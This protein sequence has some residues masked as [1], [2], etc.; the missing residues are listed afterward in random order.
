MWFAL[1]MWQLHTFFVWETGA[2]INF[3]LV[4]HYVVK[5]FKTVFAISFF[6]TLVCNI[7]RRKG[8]STCAQVLFHFQRNSFLWGYN[9]DLECRYSFWNISIT[10]YCYKLSFIVCGYSFTDQMFG[11]FRVGFEKCSEWISILFCLFILSRFK[12]FCMKP[13]NTM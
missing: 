4:I 2:I 6:L 9:L 11:T 12:L 7:S 13:I 3:E 10:F 5:L 1:I 8:F